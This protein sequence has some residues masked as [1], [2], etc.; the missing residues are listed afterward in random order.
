[1]VYYAGHGKQGDG[2]NFIIPVDAELTLP[3]HRRTRANDLADMIAA[4]P[5]DPGVGM[6]I[7]DAYRDNPL[8]RTLASRSATRSI[9][10]Q[11]R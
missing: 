7:L 4:L 1:M 5:T 9:S 10:V 2:K 6:A 8:A 11:T 3:A